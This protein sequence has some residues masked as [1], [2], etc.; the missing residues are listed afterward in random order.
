MLK[1]FRFLHHFSGKSALKYRTIFHFQPQAASNNPIR[2]KG[3]LHTSQRQ[4]AEFQ[5]LTMQ[6][7]V[8]LNLFRDQLL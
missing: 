7:S 4:T 1:V 5:F 8:D 6:P 2:F 3:F